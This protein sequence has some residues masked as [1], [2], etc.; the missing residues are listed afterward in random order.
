M[1]QMGSVLFLQRPRRASL[2]APDARGWRVHG[3]DLKLQGME[4]THHPTTGHFTKLAVLASQRFT[5]LRNRVQ[6]GMLLLQTRSGNKAW[7]L[8]TLGRLG[9]KSK[10]LLRGSYLRIKVIIFF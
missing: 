6:P 2:E 5:S 1:T 3:R 4:N 8:N 10:I 9:M 7:G